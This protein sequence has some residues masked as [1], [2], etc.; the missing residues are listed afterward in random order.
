MHRLDG[1]EVL[2]DDRLHGSPA[3]RDVALQ[4]PDEPRVVVGIDEHLDVHERAQ[5]GVGIN[6]DAFND[7]RA[8]GGDRFRRGVA[9]V[10]R[11]IVERRF[12]RTPGTQLVQVPH[13]QVGF[14]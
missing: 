5:R 2:I 12:D 13:H 7:D 6:K 1:R 3:L 11:E 9:H 8:P 4:P 10:P 14:E